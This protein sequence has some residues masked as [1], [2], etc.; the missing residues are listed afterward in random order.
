[1]DGLQCHA[2]HPGHLAHAYSRQP[3]AR[4]V[5]SPASVVGLRLW[6]LLWV[7]ILLGG[8]DGRGQDGDPDTHVAPV[9]STPSAATDVS[10]P[11]VSKP[12]PSTAADPETCRACHVAQVDDWSVSHHA[13]A[14]RPVSVALDAHAFTPS[15]DVH[16]SG[17][18]YHLTRQEDRFL[19]RVEAED[20]T[21]EDY[22]LVGVIGHT[23]VRQYLAQLPGNRFQALSALYAVEQDRWI[24]VFAGEN[25]QPGD[26]GHWTGQGMNWNANCAWCHVTDYLKNFDFSGNRYDSSW[27]RQ[28]VTCASCHGELENH[29]ASA[30]GQGPL[31]RPT[32]LA[33]KGMME[34]CAACHS[35]RDQLTAD[36]FTPG[37]RYHDHFNLSLP[38]QPGRYYPD[39]QIRDEVF[40][41]GSFAMSRMHGAGVTCLHCH[42]PHNLKTLLPVDDNSLCQSC[43][44]TG[45]LG[46]PVIKPVDHSFHSEG[47]S[48]NRCV[49]CHMPKTTYMQA[50]PRADHGFLLP[51]PLMTAT[52][53]IPNACSRCH[54]DK[55]LDW[56]VAQ[57]E[58]RHGARLAESRQRQRA[59]A[60]HGAQRGDADALAAL[61]GL[62][63]DEMIPAWRATYVGLLA[64]YLPDPRAAAAVQRAAQDLDPLVRARAAQGLTRLDSGLATAL[65]LLADESRAVRLAA[66]LPLVAGGQPLP[67]GAIG[68]EVAEYLKFH[69]DRPQALLLQAT[70]D[71][72][73][74]RRGDVLTRVRR[75]VALDSGNPES[76]HQGAVLLSGAGLNTEA[77]RILLEGQSRFPDNAQLPYALGLLAAERGE[78][79]AA[80]RHLERAVDRDPSLVRAWYNLALAYDRTGRRGEAEAAM[81]KARAGSP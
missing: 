67:P 10:F 45:T 52:L 38:D 75:A 6:A 44:A 36:G 34:T 18:T 15:R 65:D 73:A 42:N 60:L 19:V 31:T 49:N 53:G 66:A 47:S 43:H 51:D 2:K 21:V 62:L 1:M 26:W 16:E 13:G 68:G 14:N 23:P 57:A 80:I 28:G 9:P 12:R 58:Q 41:Q 81:G 37:E 76:Y 24:D 46:A 74:G 33:A 20:G 54:R 63:D 39:G 7:A 5:K 79:D 3:L 32:R 50:D 78:M 48:G 30:R 29:V 77:Q 72:R 69:Q 71:A 55:P 70:L 56:I 59:R 8:C 40:V 11:L 27:A 25:R 22:P 17:V 61:L 64:N 35:R 4:P